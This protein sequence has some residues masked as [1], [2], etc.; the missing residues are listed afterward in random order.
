MF[1]TTSAPTCLAASN[2]ASIISHTILRER[3]G[4]IETEKDGGREEGGE[5]VCVL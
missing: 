4:E 1:I 5:R 3:E 2:L